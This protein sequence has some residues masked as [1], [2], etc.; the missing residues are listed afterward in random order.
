MC[1]RYLKQYLW[2]SSVG[3]IFLLN[4]CAMFGGESGIQ[5]NQNYRVVPASG[6]TAIDAHGE[7]DQAFKLKSGNIATVTSSC[8][9]DTNSSLELMTKHL[10]LGARHIHMEKQSRVT[11]D[12][13]EGLHSE[14]TAAYEGKRF[15][16][17]LFVLPHHDCIFDFSLM[18][19]NPINPG[20]KQEFVSFVQS[21]KY[22]SN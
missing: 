11:I 8:H 4:G 13:K 18:S 19:P 16:L 14:L 1:Y 2:L 3:L 10:L 6:W 22:G 12:D 21:F 15:Y 9:R 20:D 5:R 7:S 17:N